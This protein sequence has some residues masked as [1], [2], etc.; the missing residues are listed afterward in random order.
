MHS[1]CGFDIAYMDISK[2]SECGS[3]RT[4]MDSTCGSGSLSSVSMDQVDLSNLPNAFIDQSQN[5]KK[6]SL[7]KYP[8]ETLSS[9]LLFSDMSIC[10]IC[11]TQHQMVKARKSRNQSKNSQWTDLN[12][13]EQ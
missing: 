1:N 13:F 7:L 4:T 2:R 8:H 9:F 6:V 12:V 3:A 11:H 10:Q 5:T